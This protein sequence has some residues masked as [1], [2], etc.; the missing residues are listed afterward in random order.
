M[1]HTARKT[2][3]L[4]IDN[5]LYSASSGISAAMGKR[6]HEY[7]RSMGLEEEEASALHLKYYTT[8]GLALRGLILHHDVDPLDFDKK[9]DGSL[10]LEDLIK[11][12]PS[13]RQ[14][15][16]DIDRTKVNVWG[17]TNAYRPHAERVL[18]IL[19]VDDLIDGIVFC[20]YQKPNFSCKPDAQFYRDALEKAKVPDVADVYFLDDSR[21]NVDAARALGWGHVVHFC[22][23]GLV[24][25]EG[26]KVKQ[27]AERKGPESQNGIEVIENLEEMRKIWP[28]IFK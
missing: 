17:L 12:N 22:E 10:P 11:P 6:I 19:N 16:Q 8:Y 1:S 21:I 24:H 23:T 2:V 26:G 13:L 14:L 7:F 28:E 20:D 25:V 3:F 9:C 15:L 4:D 18:R 27:I 5:T